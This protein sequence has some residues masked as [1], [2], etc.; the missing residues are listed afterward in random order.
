MEIRKHFGRFFYDASPRS[1]FM[2][3]PLPEGFDIWWPNF[4]LA[5][6]PGVI[7]DLNLQFLRVKKDIANAIAGAEVVPSEP[8]PHKVS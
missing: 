1:L 6:R 7:T 8:Y 3:P 4:M 2:G 5:S